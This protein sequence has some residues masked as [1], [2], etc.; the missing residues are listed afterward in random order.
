M[1]LCIYISICLFIYLSFY[2][3]IY[4]SMYIYIDVHIYTHTHTHIYI[5]TYIYIYIKNKPLEPFN[6]FITFLGWT[7][8]LQIRFERSSKVFCIS[9]G[10]SFWV[11]WLPPQCLSL[12]KPIKVLCFTDYHGLIKCLKHQT[13]KELLLLANK[14]DSL[15]LEKFL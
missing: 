8:F 10:I 1:Y 11:K 9:L 12:L 2:L 7:F 14:N 13:L 5:Y 6:S 4:V 3:C 15:G